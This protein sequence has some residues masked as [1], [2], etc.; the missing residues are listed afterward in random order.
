MLLFPAIDLM[1][2]QVVR[3]KQGKADQKTV[4]SAPPIA[5][6]R[7]WQDEGGDWLHIVDLDAAFSGV[8]KNLEI[9]Q[10]IAKS[11]IIPVQLGGGM[12]SPEAVR[13]AIDAGVSRVVIGTR[14]AE[15]LSFVADMV[16]EF[17]GDKIAVG[18][19]AKDGIVSVKGWTEM[20]KLTATD[21]ARQVE[22]V[23]VE[24]II[25]TDI[26]TDG[27]MQGPNFQE[28]DKMLGVIKCKLIASG[29]VSSFA[30]VQRLSQYPRIHGA[31]IGKALYDSAIR[32]HL[33]SSSRRLN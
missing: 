13:A 17:G 32:L 2:G 16:R 4:Y 15:S 11:L 18:I 10:S 31:I 5:Y 24:T 28:L 26:A 27:M 9:V 14:A 20:S 33:V 6:A 7:K 12:R 23:G 1:D 30:D 8:H 22:D 29:G 19:D 3:L 21:F 25:Y